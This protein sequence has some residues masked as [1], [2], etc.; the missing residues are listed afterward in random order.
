MRAFVLAKLCARDAS[1]VAGGGRLNLWG[2][3][4][5]SHVA[6]PRLLRNGVST[7]ERCSAKPQERV[8]DVAPV[9]RRVFAQ[10]MCFL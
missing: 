5:H 8:S 2:A 4:V 6:S 7:D 10:M 1:A 9:G 3:G